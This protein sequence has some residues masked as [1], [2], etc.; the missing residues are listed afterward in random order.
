MWGTI[1]SKHNEQVVYIQLA[2]ED[3]YSQKL[4]CE[5]WRIVW[6]TGKEKEEKGKTRREMR[7]TVK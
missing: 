6:P 3:L 7:I 2:L 4:D 5:K 1:M